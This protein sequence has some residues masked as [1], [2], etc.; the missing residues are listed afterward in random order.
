MSFS[1]FDLTCILNKD[2]R[3]QLTAIGDPWTKSVYCRG[4]NF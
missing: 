4:N 3:Y 2:F 1:P